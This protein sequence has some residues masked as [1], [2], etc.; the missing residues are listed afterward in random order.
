MFATYSGPEPDRVKLGVLKAAD[1]RLE[2]LPAL[3]ALAR[4]DWR[5]LLCEAEFPLSSRRWG[6]RE[7]APEKYEALLA[8]EQAQY[9]EW[10]GRALAT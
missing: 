4:D 8:K 3:L 1:C 6:L 2:K 10:L 5:E 9:E 7:R